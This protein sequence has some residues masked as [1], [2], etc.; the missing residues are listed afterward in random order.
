MRVESQ[1]TLQVAAIGA[2]AAAHL[3]ALQGPRTG[4]AAQSARI[5]CCVEW[6][7]AALDLDCAPWEL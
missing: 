5:V 1:V 4:R 3:Q 6:K 2:A 7:R